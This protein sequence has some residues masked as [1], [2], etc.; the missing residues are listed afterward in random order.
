MSTDTFILEPTV[1]YRLDP[2]RD[3]AGAAT[4]RTEIGEALLVFRSE[5]DAE[6][7]RRSTGRCPASEGFGA[8][9]LDHEQIADLLAAHNLSVVAMPEPWTG[10][11]ARVD[12]FT[13]ENFLQFLEESVPAEA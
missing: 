4:A 1:L 11:A 10:G 5:A 13:G 6:A 7:F 12:L 3:L 9:N 8:V 2:S